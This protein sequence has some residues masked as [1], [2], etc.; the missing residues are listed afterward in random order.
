MQLVIT[1]Y[2]DRSPAHVRDHVEATIPAAIQ[3]AADRV[4]RPT[5]ASNTDLTERGARVHGG[6]DVLDG[7]AIEWD[8]VDELT[9]VRVSIPWALDHQDEAGSRVLA[10]N[11]F[12]QVLSTGVR[13]AA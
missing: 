6:L 13:D 2:L 3:A 7:A 5:T 11:R 4:R 12:A 9:T 8:G 1:H 10:A